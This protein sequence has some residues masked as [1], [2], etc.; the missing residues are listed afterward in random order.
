[1]R[2]ENG[3][4]KAITKDIANA[5]HFHVYASE[6][7]RAP[8][9]RSRV[10][11]FATPSKEDAAL[12]PEACVRAHGEKHLG[13]VGLS[14]ARNQLGSRCACRWL[15]PYCR[16]SQAPRFRSSSRS[17]AGSRTSTFDRQDETHAV[18]S[19]DSPHSKVNSRRPSPSSRCFCVGCQT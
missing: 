17:D 19:Y 4:R 12:G 14:R 6:A 10:A 15:A 1:W 7:C 16:C 8:D 5:C 11:P 3:V 2:I 18:T 9:R 13:M